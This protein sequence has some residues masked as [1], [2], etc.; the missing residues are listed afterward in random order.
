M[1]TYVE[2]IHYNLINPKGAQRILHKYLAIKDDKSIE[3][4]YNEIVV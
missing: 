2:A 3:E 1:R 4:A